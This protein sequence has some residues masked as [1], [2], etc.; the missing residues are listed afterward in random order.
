MKKQLFLIAGAVLALASCSKDETTGVNHGNAID[1]RTAMATRA[2]ETTTASLTKFFVTALDKENANFFTD[3]EFTKQSSTFTSDP[4][5]YWP[6]DGSELDFFAYAPS[7]KDLGATVTI[8]STTKTLADFVP[9]AAIADQKDFI[10]ANAKGSK[11][12]EGTGVQLTFG[13]KLSQIEIKAKN[14]NEGY[15][16]KVQGVRI[17]KPVSKGTFDFGTSAWTLG[18]DKTNYA[19]TYE[20]SE[21]TLTA[22]AASLMATDND[23]AMLLPQQL[24]KW[25]SENDKTNTAEGAYLAVKVQITTKDGARVY[26]AAVVGDYDWVAIP[27]DTEWEVGNKYVYTLDF[28]S[29]AGLVDPEK[30]EPV[31]P[32]DPFEP[33]DPILGSPIKFTVEVTPWADANQDLDM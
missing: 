17:G 26:P 20:G 23:N 7:A 2:A 32:T 10:T 30:P 18:T 27:V 13:H 8:N 14:G 6:K 25:D 3:V 11:A 29:G 16:Y 19:V 28:T 4:A 33:G 12:N 22:T 24:T 9:A 31:D 1:F 15:V 5:Y 21:K